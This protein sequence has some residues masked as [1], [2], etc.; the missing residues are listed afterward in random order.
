MCRGILSVGPSKAERP[1]PHLG[2]LQVLQH[3]V[4]ELGRGIE[5]QELETGRRNAG[6][7]SRLSTR[8]RQWKKYAENSRVAS[9]VLG[10]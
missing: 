9:L 7:L 5:Q 4:P 2:C 1:A 6:W 10:S 3:E 8:N